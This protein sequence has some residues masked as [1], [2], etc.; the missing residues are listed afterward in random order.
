MDGNI[1]IIIPVEQQDQL[2]GTNW[3]NYRIVSQLGIGSCGT[4]YK[5]EHSA[6]QR[7]VALKIL[8]VTTD[9]EYSQR[10]LAASTANHF[11]H[12]NL[13]KTYASGKVTGR[14]FLAMDYFPGESLASLLKRCKKLPVKTA[15]AIVLGI[16]EALAALHKQGMAH[17][18]IRPGNIHITAQGTPMLIACDLA[19]WVNFRKIIETGAEQAMIVPP[20][21][22]APESV[23]T[24]QAG[25]ATAD[26]Y[27]LGMTFYRLVTGIVPFFH[28]EIKEVLKRLTHSPIASPSK[29]DKSLPGSLVWAMEKM[30]EKKPQDRFRNG[31]ELL[32][33]LQG[34]HLQLQM[35]VDDGEIEP[36][37]AASMSAA[38]PPTYDFIE[39][40]ASPPPPP[41]L[42]FAEP[43]PPALD[44]A[45][46]PPPALDFVEPPP[47]AL[48][49]AEPP[50]PTL[51]FAEPPP[52]AL[53]F[54]EPPPEDP[55]FP[56][57]PDMAGDDNA[58][59]VAFSDDD[60]AM[61]L[62]DPTSIQDFVSA[63]EIADTGASAAPIAPAPAASR[64]KPAKKR[65]TVAATPGDAR[66]RQRI[67]MVIAIGVL[68]IL[69]A[70]YALFSGKKKPPK[71]V[72][73]KAPTVAEKRAQACYE[74]EQKLQG[75]LAS[76]DI[77][78]WQQMQ[79]QVRDFLQQHGGSSEAKKLAKYPE[80][81][82]Q[83]I[84][85]KQARDYYRN[86]EKKIAS[87]IEK[88]D[89]AQAWQLLQ[90][91]A[92]TPHQ[93]L[94][95]TKAEELQQRIETAALAKAKAVN[96]H[97][98]QMIVKD[99]QHAQALEILQQAKK[100]QI[101]S[102]LGLLD[103]QI[104]SVQKQLAQIRQAVFEWRLQKTIYPLL[105]RKEFLRASQ[106]LDKEKLQTSRHQEIIARFSKEVQQMAELERIFYEILASELKK[107]RHKF[108][109]VREV[110]R[111]RQLIRIEGKV[112]RAEK[113][114]NIMIF[115][116][117]GVSSFPIERMTWGTKR[118]ILKLRLQ[119]RPN[120][121]YQL[122]LWQLI[123]GNMRL[124]NREM[125]GLPVELLTS[126]QKKQAC[127]LVTE[128]EALLTQAQL[129][130]DKAGAILQTLN[131]KYRHQEIWALLKHEVAVWLDQAARSALA[132]RDKARAIMLYRLIADHLS[133]T[134]AYPRAQRQLA[135]LRKG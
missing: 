37:N 24:S 107:N 84:A 108:T 54:V 89:F 68:I 30:I 57:S 23:Y 132:G 52:P 91:L 56:V 92:S 72:V 45:E 112:F 111:K 110:N 97:C 118:R 29:I 98:E 32:D 85:G 65:P 38:T 35:V 48:D 4:T 41:A 70:G 71:K 103:R 117:G 73:P 133:G 31:Q 102:A 55:V 59:Q 100:Q 93:R 36:S 15:M 77:N 44:F 99:G 135:Q 39:T 58:N 121:R 9:A 20:Y 67:I 10:F 18:D 22:L 130:H 82:R 74:L 43:P 7:N 6:S 83:K 49:F 80:L 27:S 60:S 79:T 61:S 1:P 25:N 28:P 120:Y 78:L 62:A 134:E 101:A 95:Q 17:G 34:I 50:P 5:A 90:Q 81:L 124:A 33:I 63:S 126:L 119:S 86:L 96:R 14:L 76:E 69:I 105:A 122:A 21:Y 16:A 47:P 40:S 3:G 11:D 116:K 127:R 87:L 88:D 42:D 131:Q 13:I 26:T 114:G 2:C 129:I 115:K 113:N 94:L 12:P 8:T 128:L 51:D 123:L 75:A 109:F 104:E 66:Q 64:P 46:P 19:R 53:D 106:K 125:Q